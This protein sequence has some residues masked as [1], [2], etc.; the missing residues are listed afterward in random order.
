M[1]FR[2]E[3]FERNNSTDIYRHTCYGIYFLIAIV[4]TN[5]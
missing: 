3:G 2:N 5:L 4:N 1:I